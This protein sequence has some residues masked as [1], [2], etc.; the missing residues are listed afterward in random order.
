MTMSPF[1]Q[2]VFNQY[3]LQ[4]KPAGGREAVEAELAAAR[5]K[6]AQLEEDLRL[7]GDGNEI[8]EFL[9]QSE[10]L[11]GSHATEAV[12]LH[13]TVARFGGCEVVAKVKTRRARKAAPA[14]PVSAATAGSTLVESDEEIEGEA[15]GVSVIA[16]DDEPITQAEKNLIL[17]QLTRES[18]SIN[19]IAAATSAHTND[20]WKA[21]DISPILKEL[22]KDG[23]VA[24]EGENRA[25]RY[26][27]APSAV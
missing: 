11:M 22:I 4:H 2:E 24:F 5:A 6:V 19:E 20:Q 13:M 3:M 27:L 1:L 26:L 9:I 10:K 8:E 23:T 21:A 25:K 14:S 7:L 17:A 15:T 18:M 16:K 12:L